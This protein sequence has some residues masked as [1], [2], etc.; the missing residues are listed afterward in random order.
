MR[1]LLFFAAI[2][3]VSFIALSVF[4][5]AAFLYAQEVP[6]EKVS[7]QDGSSVERSVE[8]YSPAPTSEAAKTAGLWNGGKAG[9]SDVQLFDLFLNY[10]RGYKPKQPIAYNH[11]VHVEKSGLECQYCHSGVSKGPY[12]TVPAVELCMDCH[13]VITTVNGVSSPEIKKLAEYWEKRIPIEWKSVSSLP[14]VS[15]F[16]HERHIKSGVG[17]Q[18]CH[19]Q[20]QRMVEVE[21]VSSFK[22]G[23][24]VSCHR[25]R[26]AS[27]DCTGCHY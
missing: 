5:R 1:T 21:K 27:T 4:S 9:F 8:R 6:Q 12:A 11:Q 13:R 7:H 26:G 24:C 25:E 3:S 22:M 23:F 20:V 14:E 15:H 10:A 18:L 2:A 16:N 19:G 17:C